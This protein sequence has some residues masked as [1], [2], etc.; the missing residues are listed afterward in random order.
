[1]QPQLQLQYG[2]GDYKNYDVSDCNLKIIITGPRVLKLTS[3]ESLMTFP[4]LCVMVLSYV[5]TSKPFSRGTSDYLK[6]GPNELL[7]L[8]LKNIPSDEPPFENS[9]TI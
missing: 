9:L 2:F 4:N 1:M 6:K 8:G 7:L 5:L 3:L